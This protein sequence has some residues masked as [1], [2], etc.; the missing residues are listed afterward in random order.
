MSDKKISA[1]TAASTP[2]AGTE[3]LPVVQSGVTKQVSVANLTVGRPVSGAS[4]IPTSATVPVNGM[5]L[6]AANSVSIAT[7]STEHWMVN[8]SGNLNP[9]GA[10]GIGTA[11]API[12]GV[13]STEITLTTGNLIVGTAGKGIDFSADPAAAGMT[14]ELLD[15]YEEGT[16]TPVDASGAGL[17]FVDPV[18]KYTKIGN[19][20]RAS[21][22]F[23]FPATADTS[24]ILIGGLPFAIGS[25]QSDRQ[26]F[27]SYNSSANVGDL[28]LPQLNTTNFQ[29]RGTSGSLPKNN[30]YSNAVVILTCL[31]AV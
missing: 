2:L 23:G 12:N 6:G 5:F 13:Y 28:V 27:F 25:S 21:C 18:G 3:V 24:D 14:S 26:G 22:S 1:L 11:L 8:A 16:W 29:F 20:V 19:T 17:T 7:N 15:D 31:Y 9:V 4:F 10:K 30:V